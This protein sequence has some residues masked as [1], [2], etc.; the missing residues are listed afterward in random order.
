MKLNMSK[1]KHLNNKLFYMSSVS[2]QVDPYITIIAALSRQ[3]I[4]K[5]KINIKKLLKCLK[6]NNIKV[7]YNI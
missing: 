5:R 1:T 3:K 2:K 6:I 4:S 7:I